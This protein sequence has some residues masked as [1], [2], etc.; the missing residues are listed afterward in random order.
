MSCW[1]QQ[2]LTE[3]PASRST[4]CDCAAS[5]DTAL[6]IIFTCIM[7]IASC[8]LQSQGETYLIPAKL[9]LDSG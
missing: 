8:D 6:G 1:H 2:E 7:L 4:D 3:A 5:F 9:L